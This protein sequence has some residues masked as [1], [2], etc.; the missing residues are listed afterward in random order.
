MKLFM[1]Q[2]EAFES[3]SGSFRMNG[4]SITLLSHA[5]AGRAPLTG[6]SAARGPLAVP[7]PRN[8]SILVVFFAPT[9]AR[10]SSKRRHGWLCAQRRRLRE[11][12][13]CSSYVVGEKKIMKKNDSK[14]KC[15]HGLRDVRSRAIAG[16][17]RIRRNG[18][19]GAPEVNV[20][21]LLIL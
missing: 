3:N 16:R 13:G 10:R 4:S 19:A 20:S 6:T 2:V 15:S 5:M 1:P 9:V 7:P 11:R 21:L 18:S 12:S 8:F 14:E 17:A